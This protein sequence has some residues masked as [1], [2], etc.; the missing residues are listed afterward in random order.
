MR[1][2]LAEANEKPQGALPAA[3][4]VRRETPGIAIGHQKEFWQHDLPQVAL[5]T[6]P[7]PM[8]AVD[9]EG[10]VR[11][12]NPAAERV[13]GWERREIVGH[14]L[15]FPASE[16]PAEQLMS[17]SSGHRLSNKRGEPVD[18]AL[19]SNPICDVR[20]AVRGTL[21]VAAEASQRSAAV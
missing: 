16:E 3:Q 5:D 4:A 9:L 6:T 13:F 14:R 10:N 15:P 1:L 21:T 2:R 12:W 19:W 11:Y 7:V 20:G 17:N 18:V 8:F